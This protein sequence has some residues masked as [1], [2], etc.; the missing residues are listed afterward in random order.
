VVNCN[1]GGCLEMKVANLGDTSSR[2]TGSRDPERCN[3]P[4]HDVKDVQV[5]VW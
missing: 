5:A 4:M 2:V 1:E 3:R